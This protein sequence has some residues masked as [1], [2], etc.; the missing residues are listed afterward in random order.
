M[1]KGKYNYIILGVG[2]ILLIIASIVVINKIN[3][4]NSKD[5]LQVDKTVTYEKYIGRW[6]QDKKEENVYVHIKSTDNNR[7]KFDFSSKLFLKNL[8]AILVNNESTLNIDNEHGAFKLK[9]RVVNNEIRLIV[10][11]SKNV[12][13]NNNETYL[14]KVK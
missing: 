14:F 10:K 9:I 3:K 12:Y 13:F 8:E 4:G 6:Y 2:V 1:K 7:I 5:E 11:D